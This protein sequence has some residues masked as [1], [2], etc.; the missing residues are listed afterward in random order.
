VQNDFT[1]KALFFAIGQAPNTYSNKHTRVGGNV[2]TGFKSGIPRKMSSEPNHWVV[3]TGTIH[4][5]S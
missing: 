5:K 3:T 4:Y 1:K 2:V